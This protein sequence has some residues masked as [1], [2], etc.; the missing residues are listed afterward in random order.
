VPCRF[1]HPGKALLAES[2]HALR[3][4]EDD[5]HAAREAAARGDPETVG[6]PP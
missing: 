1:Q 4:N 3:V 5:R 6:M 2:V